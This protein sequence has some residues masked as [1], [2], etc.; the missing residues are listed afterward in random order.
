MSL[1]LLIESAPD[2]VRKAS[3]FVFF[4]ASLVYFGMSV[5]FSDFTTWFYHTMPKS[6]YDALVKEIEQLEKVER[7]RISGQI[8]EAKEKGDLSE[9]A[10]YD[11][12]K[13]AQGMLEAKI[14]YLEGVIATAR[15][16]DES[17]I[18]KSIDGS[19]RRKLIKY[20]SW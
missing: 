14:K 1:A 5:N 12:A 2:I 4:T 6:I 9:N 8:A 3:S 19:T 13:E 11:A 7:R 20:F 18:L 17:S 16:L 15:I 10:E